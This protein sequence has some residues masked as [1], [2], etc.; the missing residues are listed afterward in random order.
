MKQVKAEYEPFWYCPKCKNLTEGCDETDK[1]NS[2][3]D[4]IDVVCHHLTDYRVEES[5]D[6]QCSH[7][8]TVIL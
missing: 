3:G 1:W 7:E 8:Y 4:T 2:N 6:N 5:E